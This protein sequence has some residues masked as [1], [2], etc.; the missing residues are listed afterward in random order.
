MT[1]A[2]TLAAT[3]ALLALLSL[4]L[5]PPARGS[6]A[7]LAHS[8]LKSD[9]LELTSSNWDVPSLSAKDFGVR[10]DGVSDDQPGL[11]AAIDAAQRSARTLW[12]PAG[13]Y[14]VNRTLI[15]NPFRHDVRDSE[16]KPLRLL[17]EGEIATTIVAGRP[18]DT[19]LDILPCTKPVTHSS[20]GHSLE[21]LT[22]DSADSAVGG[23]PTGLGGKALA[24]YSIRA[25]A[26]TRTWLIRV[27]ATGAAIAG[28]FLSHGWS[29]R[30]LSCR[31]SN[32]P[33]SGLH[34]VAALNNVVVANSL[35]EQNGAGPNGSAHH[36]G[37][38][39]DRGIQVSLRGNTI[40][41][42][43]G[44]GVVANSVNGLSVTECYFESNNYNPVSLHGHGWAPAVRVCADVVLIGANSVLP[45]LGGAPPSLVLSAHQPCAGASIRSSTFLPSDACSSQAAAV[46]LG[47]VVGASITANT[48]FGGRAVAAVGTDLAFWAA[49]SVDFSA[50]ANQKSAGPDEL[51]AVLLLPPTVAAN[52]SD[53]TIPHNSIQCHTFRSS[54]VSQRNFALAPSKWL[55]A[56]EMPMPAT[57]DLLDDEFD[58]LPQWRWQAGV[59]VASTMAVVARVALDRTPSLTGKAVYAT[60]FCESVTSSTVSLQF[61]SNGVWLMAPSITL[62]AGETTR[63][64]TQIMA[65]ANGTLQLALRVVRAE[66]NATVHFGRVVLAS[67]GAG[68]KTDDSWKQDVFAIGNWV[69]P[70]IEPNKFWR[71]DMK[72]RLAEM[73]D[74]NFTVLLGTT[75]IVSQSWSESVIAMT[76]YAEQFGL[77]I[78]PGVRQLGF[79][80]S[81]VTGNIN[82]T[83]GESTLILNR[84]QIDS[85]I[86]NSTAFWGFDLCKI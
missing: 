2:T 7:P 15:V 41:G 57:I 43:H 65:S 25:V 79:P 63:V 35:I 54:S 30:L 49:S 3:T 23:P 86:T 26:T 72:R 58:G 38:V 9:E 67:I 24:N 73:A 76:G 1:S 60:V 85:R 32:N 40:E 39:I 4:L 46:M 84:T 83:S 33:G 18:L 14:R 47:A 62:R 19:V 70:A 28:V 8:G 20:T 52:S 5:C 13:R 48:L 12:L 71:H 6:E 66:G 45:E 56:H 68:L 75:G 34:M 29:N 78:V 61:G 11:Q 53:R 10:G 16:F 59:G 21:H 27:H 81:P 69:A 17:G 77:K 80:G 31:L 64:G 37:I 50:N 74:A 44:P 36:P 42:N 51:P 55:S 22:V 82:R